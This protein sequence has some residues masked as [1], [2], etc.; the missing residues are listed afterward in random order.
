M[1]CPLSSDDLKKSSHSSLSVLSDRILFP[2]AIPSIFE[3]PPCTKLQ[4]QSGPK[5]RAFLQRP[6]KCPCLAK[7]VVMKGTDNDGDTQASEPYF[8]AVDKSMEDTDDVNDTPA[9]ESSMKIFVQVLQNH[10]YLAILPDGKEQHEGGLKRI[11]E[12]EKKNVTLQR[13]FDKLEQRFPIMRNLRDRDTGF[14]AASRITK[15]PVFLTLLAHLRSKAS[16]LRWWRRKRPS[17][18]CV[19]VDAV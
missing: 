12:L 1:L 14:S 6:R 9:R 19:K 17:G 2:T 11:W 13:R 5:E 8:L 10:H 7:N 3:L 15:H 4:S 16:H 18:G